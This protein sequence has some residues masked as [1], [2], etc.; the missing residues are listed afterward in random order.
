MK[1]FTYQILFFAGILAMILTIMSCEEY[2]DKAPEATITE[3]DVYG[4]FRSYQ[5]FIEELYGRVVDI[6]KTGGDMPQFLWA[7]ESISSSGH[8]NSD[9]GNYWSQGYIGNLWSN[10]W[11]GIK[12]AN[13]ALSKLDLMVEGTQ[14]EKD[15][16][17]GQAL[18]FRGFLHFEIIKWF[19]GMPYVDTYITPGEVLRYP[20]LS[21]RETSLKAAEDLKAAAEL[22]PVNWD[23]IPAGQMTLGNNRQRISKVHALG[24]MG[25]VLLYAASPM[26]N[27]ES[28]GNSGYDADL[29]KQSAE[30]LAEAIEICEQTGVFSLQSWET[31]TDNFWVDS[32][33][34]KL[35]SGGTEA[36]MLGG[37][38]AKNKVRWAAVQRYVLASLGVPYN[39]L[40]VPTHNWVKNYYMANGLP[41]TDPASG[42][43]PNNP[44]DG[45]E[46]RFYKD[47][48]VDGDQIVNS[49]Q[50]GD[51]RF[52]QLYTGGRHRAATG[53]SYT[54]YLM[55]RWAPIGCNL[56]DSRWDN[57]QFFI[58]HLRLAEV[59][60]LYAE[61]V[62]NGYG[63]PQSS[64]PGSITATEAVNIIRNRAQLPSLTA[65][66]TATKQVFM[67]DLIQ[68][69]AVELA[70]DSNR[71]H[72]LR[73]WN[74]S[75]HVRY[76]VKTA[77]EFDR[78]P[79]GKPINISEREIITRVVEPKHNWLPLNVN[80]TKL[81]P[82]FYQNPGW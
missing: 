67:D 30:A 66:F 54:G 41:I 78:D 13:L 68:E 80:D 35:M 18:F 2:L 47:I 37:P 20:R 51:D 73:R 33:N 72:D 12:K 43:D 17:K 69:R 55:K 70:W 39:T 16:I 52:A 62:V 26:M 45:R 76:K 25:K 1:K 11:Y 56:W 32:P 38:E 23:A 21:Y 15:L 61:A 29:C 14:E 59:Y 64:A 9:L 4:N 44:W 34:N 81:Y 74:L 75:G 57:Y 6:G 50:G 27:E 8:H 36:I 31:W 82:E 79:L 58:P 40:E 48:V 28:T 63:T 24:I 7:D 53:G 5:G 65:A 49:S 3:K 19:G 71:F 10:A 60:L 77:V 22:L 46:P 42:Y